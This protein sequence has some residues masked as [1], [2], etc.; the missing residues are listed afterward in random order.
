MFNIHILRNGKYHKI[1]VVSFFIAL[2]SRKVSPCDTTHFHQLT[3]DN[4]TTYT[5]L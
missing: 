4:K 1:S 3:E 2:H 5:L